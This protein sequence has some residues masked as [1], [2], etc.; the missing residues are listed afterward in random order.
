MFFRTLMFLLL[1]VS[2]YPF[3]GEVTLSNI[4]PDHYSQLN[5]TSFE[6]NSSMYDTLRT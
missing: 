5:S 1:D 6:A 4:L 2:F 3:S